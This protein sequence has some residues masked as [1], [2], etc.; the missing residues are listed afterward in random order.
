MFWILKEIVLIIHSCFSYTKLRLFLPLLPAAG[1]EAGDVQRAGSGHSQDTWHL[2][3]KEIFCVLC[4]HAQCI[5]L[6]EE[7]REGH[8]E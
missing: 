8:L 1:Q 2:L 3:T 6:D 4:H 5:K 7:G